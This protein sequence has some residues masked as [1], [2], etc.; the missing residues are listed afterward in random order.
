MTSITKARLCDDA[1]LEIESRDSEIRSNAVDEPIVKSVQVKSLSMEATR[2]AMCKCWNLV[3]CSFVIRSCF[4][5]DSTKDGHSLRKI[6]APVK[7]PSPPQTTNESMPLLMR[8]KAPCSRPSWLINSL[9]RADPISVPPWFSQPRTS[10][11][12]TLIMYWSWN[13]ESPPPRSPKRKKS[14][15]PYDNAFCPK[16]ASSAARMSWLRLPFSRPAKPSRMTNASSPL[17]KAILIT[18][19]IAEFMPEQSPPDV[20]IASRR[21][22]ISFMF[23]V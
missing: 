19:H 22:C 8:L 18:A 20:R 5:S 4:N 23:E 1:V 11:Q 13:L 17:Y 14:P 15:H 16:F 2:P 21:P 6:S 7:L 3:A 12:P 10:S 9:H